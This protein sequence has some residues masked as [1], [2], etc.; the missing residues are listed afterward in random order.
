MSMKELLETAEYQKMFGSISE[1]L[2]MLVKQLI[3]CNDSNLVRELQGEIRGLVWCRDTLPQELRAR[4]AA[5]DQ[6]PEP[7]LTPEESMFGGEDD[8][9][10]P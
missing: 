3:T 10:E 8:E 9:L 1:K 5:A 2:D 6:E 4:E 7:V